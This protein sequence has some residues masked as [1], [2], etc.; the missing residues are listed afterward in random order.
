VRYAC[1]TR[2]VLFP[3]KCIASD[4]FA[5]LC[6]PSL[7]GMRLKIEPRL[8]AGEGAAAIEPKSPP[9]CFTHAERKPGFM[10]LADRIFNRAPC[11]LL[12]EF[13]MASSHHEGRW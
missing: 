13:V 5:E 4:K 10:R 7:T 11:R 9:H 8:H 2:F 1:G 12:R 6:R 3:R